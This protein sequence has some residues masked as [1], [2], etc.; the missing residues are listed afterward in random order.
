METIS[1]QMTL[2]KRNSSVE[3]KLA[4][5]KAHMKNIECGREIAPTPVIKI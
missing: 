4:I 5:K 3:K 2:C 1:P